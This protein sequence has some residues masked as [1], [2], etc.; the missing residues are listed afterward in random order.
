MIHDDDEEELLLSQLQKAQLCNSFDVYQYQGFWCP[1][2]CFHGIITS[3][4]HF[5]AKHIDI[6]LTSFPISGTTW[7]KAITFSIVNRSRYGLQNS[8]LLTTNPHQ[9]VPFL[10]FNDFFPTHSPFAS[11]PLSIL[12][13]NCGIV[14]LRTNP[15]DQFITDWQ[16]I[17]RLRDLE[18]SR[19]DE[20]FERA[21]PKRDLT[22]C[23]KRLADFLRCSFSEGEEANGVI[24]EISKL[25]SFDNIKGLEATKKGEVGD[26]KNYLTPSM[27][28]HMVKMMEEKSAGSG[29]TFKLP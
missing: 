25:C 20:A 1:Y 15:L 22:F 16:F 21:Y 5:E 26:W 14:Y 13:S 9:L 8:P 29:L 12:T 7:L 10:E 11:L 4:K 23:V 17:P 6:M 19:I 3:Q 27:S 2:V 24:E 18:P 28:E